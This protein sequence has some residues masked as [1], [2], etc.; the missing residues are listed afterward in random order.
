MA[1]FLARPSRILS[2]QSRCTRLFASSA[3]ACVS[4]HPDA[5]DNGSY[6][7]AFMDD[8]VDEFGGLRHD[9][10]LQSSSS[11]SAYRS[12]E[13]NRQQYSRP[14]YRGRVPLGPGRESRYRD[15]FLQHEID[16]RR[17]AHNEELMSGY[18]SR[19]GQI[20]PR[21]VTN[22]SQR[23][24]RLVGKA[25]KRA[26]MMGV[27]PVFSNTRLRRLEV[28]SDTLVNNNA[29]D[30]SED[31]AEENEEQNEDKDED[32]NGKDNAVQ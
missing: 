21:N 9:G 4:Q 26:K 2:A 10:N 13:F 5:V 24:Q 22:L 12:I 29:E 18:M 23:S 20:K 30:T 31:K 6:L 28:R 19:L 8:M 32:K 7:T 16:P 25:I 14:S 27:V 11:T 1:S 3:N 15:I 17:E